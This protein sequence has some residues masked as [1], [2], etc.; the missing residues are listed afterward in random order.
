MEI[1]EVKFERKFLITVKMLDGKWIL[2]WNSTVITK[3]QVYIKLFFVWI[4]F[5]YLRLLLI[6]INTMWRDI[7]VDKPDITIKTRKINQIIFQ[8]EFFKLLT[9]T[10]CFSEFVDH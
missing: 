1:A 3:V 9:P 8:V 7:Q 5:N 2:F 4:K 10:L 6:C